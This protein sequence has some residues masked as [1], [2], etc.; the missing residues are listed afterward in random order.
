MTTQQNKNVKI[1][2]GV[3]AGLLVLYFILNNH[4]DNGG[5]IVDPTGNNTAPD[6]INSFSANKVRLELFDAMNKF[7]TDEDTI[8]DALRYVNQTQF[9]QVF[10]AFGQERYDDVLGYKT[11]Y[12]TPRD[13]AYWLKSEL[14]NDLYSNLKRKYPEKL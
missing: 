13:L 11:S 6:V 5:G 10:K 12:G 9:S 2:V 4:P 3:G 8:I 7:G 1:A 14:S